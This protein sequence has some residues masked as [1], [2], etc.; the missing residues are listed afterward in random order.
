MSNS[1]SPG[2]AK[3][4]NTDHPIHEL[5]SKRW[6]PRAFADRAVQGEDLKSLMESA[7]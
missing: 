4:A 7:W 1:Q 3:A 6:S 2:K 5:L